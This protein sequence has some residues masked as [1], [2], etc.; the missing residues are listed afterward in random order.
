MLQLLH[1]TSTYQSIKFSFIEQKGYPPDT[2][3]TGFTNELGVGKL[4][5]R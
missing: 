1:K 4:Y 3:A 5:E 2:N